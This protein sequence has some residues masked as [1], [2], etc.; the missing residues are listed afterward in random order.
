MIKVVIHFYFLFDND[1][2]IILIIFYSN[3]INL[4]SLTLSDMKIIVGINK[5][6]SM[7]KNNGII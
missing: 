2:L 4:T 5:L 6:I 3:P 1:Y 7:E